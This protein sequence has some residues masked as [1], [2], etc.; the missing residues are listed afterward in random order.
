MTRLV[1]WGSCGLFVLAA[2]MAAYG[3]YTY[4]VPS[5]QQANAGSSP[6]LASGPSGSVEP[7]RVRVDLGQVALS[8]VTPFEVSLKHLDTRPARVAGAPS[9]CIRSGCV[10]FENPP[11]G[12]TPGQPV[13]LKMLCEAKTA[14]PLEIET[15]LY[16]DYGDLQGVSV[17]ITVTARVVDSKATKAD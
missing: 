2:G 3:V 1:R 7:A 9:C 4:A 5:A 12:L 14:G 10:V 17:P 15:S 13:T 16:L 6:G 11:A 8:S